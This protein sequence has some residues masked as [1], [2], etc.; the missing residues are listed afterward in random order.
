VKLCKTIDTDN[1]GFVTKEELFNGFDAEVEFRD[2]LNVMDIQKKDMKQVFKIMDQDKSGDI[3]YSEFGEQLALIQSQDIRTTM[4]FIKHWILDLKVDVDELLKSSG[5]QRG[6]SLSCRSVSLRTSRR[7]ASANTYSTNDENANMPSL[8]PSAQL[9]TGE[10]SGKE[11]LP[12]MTD[13]KSDKLTQAKRA[14]DAV[15]APRCEATD[16]LHTELMVAFGELEKR[17]RQQLGDIGSQFQQSLPS[18]G[19]SLSTCIGGCAPREE[20]RSC[21]I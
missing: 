19:I 11:P 16:W 14:G 1:S 15:P 7:A 18:H 3:S 8:S 20:S 12:I 10:E 4:A 6:C 5:I 13:N 21:G 9:T 2:T 17:L